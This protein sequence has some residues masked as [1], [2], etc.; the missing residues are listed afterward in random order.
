MAVH[1]N[2]EDLLSRLSLEEKIA[3]LGGVMV[4][5]LL[6]D[7]QVI[8]DDKL[9][10]NLASGIGFLSAGTPI[11]QSPDQ[12]ATQI[13]SIQRFLL[14][15]TRASIPAMPHA[16]ALA[17]LMMAPAT[18]FPTPVNLAATWNPALIEQV[19]LTIGR[20]MLAAGLRQA[21]SPVLDVGRDPRWGRFNETFGEN[22]H[23]CAA[24]G[25]AF[26]KGVQSLQDGLQV[27]A[28]GKHFLGYGQPSAGLN[29]A[30]VSI[31]WRELYE[32]FA[33][34]FEAA[35]RHGELASVMTSYSEVDG[36]V[37][38]AS[39]RILTGLLREQLG[40][41]GVVVSDFLAIQ[42]IRGMKRLTPDKAEA[43]I[44]A[45]R[46]GLDVEL[47]SLNYYKTLVASVKDGRIAEAE[48]DALVLHVLE[49][50]KRAGL[51][52]RP[53]VETEAAQRYYD[54]PAS[55]ALATDVAAHSLV[56]LKN[57]GA[58]P[59]AASVRKIAVLGPMADSVRAFFSG[60]TPAAM[61]EVMA[62]PDLGLD[63]GDQ[64]SGEDIN[65]Q[66]AF[67]VTDE[68]PE[69]VFSRSNSRPQI[70]DEFEAEPAER[71]S[72]TQTVRQLYPGTK[73]VLE[74]LRSASAAGIE[75]CHA[76]GCTPLGSG[77]QDIAAGAAHLAAECDL[78]ICV[79]GQKAGWALDAVSGENRDQANLRLTGQQERLICEVAAT[80]TPTVI[81]LLANQ[82]LILE[83]FIEKAS[84][85][86]WA[87]NPG[88]GGGKVIAETLLG[89]R[90]P[91]GKLPFT[92]PRHVGQLPIHAD[93]RPSGGP[94]AMGYYTDARKIPRYW[95]GHG[96]SYTQFAY[97]NLEIAP[98]SVPADGCVEISF[99]LTNKGARAGDEV[100]QLY[101]RDRYASMTRPQR[102]LG[103]FTRITLQ[104]G[105]TRRIVFTVHAEQL[106]FLDAEMQLIVEPGA[107]DL[108][109]GPSSAEEA[110][111][112]MFE[113]VGPA[114]HLPW[115]THFWADVQVS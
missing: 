56:L 86:I 37:V 80:G 22:P 92:I 106:A 11:G 36:E 85:V 99:D 63:S 74:E 32:V 87:G 30:P 12:C 70:I 13:N 68:Q 72:V 114:L 89:H 47:P 38:S 82:P 28:T 77:P 41:E 51:F 50:K 91:G 18:S 115:R 59:L 113:I 66:D 61:A 67:T 71:E 29:T 94:G 15:R 8:S 53:F 105:E 21:D 3:Q 19:G 27:L 84:A 112:G 49:N 26:V 6:T 111:E 102:Q 42:W 1:I 17:G 60:Y 110:L 58:L 96:L 52:E 44:L 69:I 104:P 20:E 83:A 103:G 73:S 4:S 90:A 98:A 10:S 57:E 34:P 24:I 39:R 97:S 93:H 14:E 101:L 107:V 65:I 9:Q 78:A 81:V 109:I 76:E 55:R 40:F 100:A 88:A 2:L 16:E 48:I 5:E 54:L 75:I 7:D 108:F 35:V 62:A 23:L 31:G 95:L 46:A 25:T 45:A 33:T 79:V 43:A 64:D